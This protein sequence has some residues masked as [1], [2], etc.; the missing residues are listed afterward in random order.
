MEVS[1]GEAQWV[2]GTQD[3]PDPTKL[4]TVNE[5]KVLSS[6]RLT[7]LISVSLNI[8]S[9]KNRGGGGGIAKKRVVK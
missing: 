3:K 8:K 6:P 5:L 4:K 1:K 9:L 2:G 7:F